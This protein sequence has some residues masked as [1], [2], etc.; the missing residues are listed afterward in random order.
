MKTI[1][2]YLLAKDLT[3]DFEKVY[4]GVQWGVELE[5]FDAIEE[6]LKEKL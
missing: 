3:D 4:K 5:Y 2:L 1:D 6:F